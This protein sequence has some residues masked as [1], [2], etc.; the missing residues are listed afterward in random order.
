MRIYLKSLSYVY[1][2][3][4]SLSLIITF[5]HYFNIMNEKVANISMF[6]VPIISLII[7]GFIVGKVAFK[8]GWLEGLKLAGIVIVIM[9]L[10]TLITNLGL[11]FKTILYYILITVSATIGGMLGISKKKNETA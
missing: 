7:G 11:S 4:F 9:F 3:M 1:G 10:L 2:A 5:F 8:K 6:M